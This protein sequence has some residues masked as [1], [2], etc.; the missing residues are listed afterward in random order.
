MRQEGCREFIRASLVIVPWN[1]IYNG[2][3]ASGFQL[4]TTGEEALQKKRERLY[5]FAEIIR[6]DGMT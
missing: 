4:T 2:K 1:W 5:D 6:R 3:H